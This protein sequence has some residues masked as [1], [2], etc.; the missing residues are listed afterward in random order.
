MKKFILSIG[1]VLAVLLASFAAFAQN[2]NR[3]N[4]AQQQNMR[5][6]FQNMSPEQRQKLREEMLQRR[7]QWQN[8]SDEERQKFR[9]EMLERFGSESQGMDYDQQLKSIKVIEEQLAKLKAAVEA[10]SPENRERTRELPEE[11]RTSLREKMTAAMRERQAS[12]RAIEQE[13]AKLRAPARPV[14]PPRLRTS[15]L[16]A[17]QKLAVEENA[18]RTAERLQRFIA[19]YERELRGRVL[20]PMQRPREGEPKQRLERPARPE[21]T[22]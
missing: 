9:A 20:T 19:G 8:M 11:E 10:V 2:A 16:Q 4:P 5:Q 18:P 3:A 12:I 6:R 15:E 21:K 13:L 22:E 17:I 7:Q 14:T 1:I